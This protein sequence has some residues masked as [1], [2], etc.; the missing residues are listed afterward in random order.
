MFDEDGIF[1]TLGALKPNYKIY[2]PNISLRNNISPGVEA[3]L[4]TGGNMSDVHLRYG[5]IRNHHLILMSFG[6]DCKPI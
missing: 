3:G 6:K 2:A 5:H 1:V 4:V